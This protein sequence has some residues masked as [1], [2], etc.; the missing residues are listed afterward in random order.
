MNRV[1]RQWRC[2]DC[3]DP[4]ALSNDWFRPVAVVDGW[5]SMTCPL[6]RR[7]EVL[8][9]LGPKTIGTVL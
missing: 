5:D 3:T 6:V 1:A 2:G 7:L 9:R 4:S 8:S